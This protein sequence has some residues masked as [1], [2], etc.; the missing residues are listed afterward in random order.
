MLQVCPEATSSCPLHVEE[1]EMIAE[2]RKSSISSRA[3]LCHQ[4]ALL[5]KA[6]LHHFL[7]MCSDFLGR[8]SFLHSARFFRKLSMLWDHH[9]TLCSR[10]ASALPPVQFFVNFFKSFVSTPALRCHRWLCSAPQECR[11]ARGDSP[12][13]L[14]ASEHTKQGAKT[15][16]RG[17]CHDGDDLF[18]FSKKSA[19]FTQCTNTCC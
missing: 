10:A 7:Q 14:R 6:A 1:R 16:T 9:C 5:S 17:E 2:T 3:S 4:H 15:S 12:Q 8:S 19:Q 13:L 18:F 11:E